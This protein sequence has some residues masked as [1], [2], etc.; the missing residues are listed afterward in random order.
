MHTPYTVAKLFNYSLTML[1]VQKNSKQ[2]F[3]ATGMVYVRKAGFC[4]DSNILYIAT[5][6]S[7]NNIRTTKQPY[8]C[9]LNQYMYVR[10]F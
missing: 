6:I 10:T 1:G 7:N 9:I 2:N 3:Q 4:L 5:Y 8:N